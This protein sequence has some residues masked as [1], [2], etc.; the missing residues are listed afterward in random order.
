MK[1]RLLR[2][3]VLFVSISFAGQYAHADRITSVS[4]EPGQVAKL[5]EFKVDDLRNMLK[6]SERVTYCGSTAVWH[7]FIFS[8]SSPTGELSRW[9]GSFKCSRK[10]VAIEKEMEIDASGVAE[11]PNFLL[12]TRRLISCSTDGSLILDGHLLKSELGPIAPG[13][14]LIKRPNQAPEPTPTSVTPPARQ[15]ARQP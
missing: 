1:Y 7:F 4:I 6:G 3:L 9:W 5:Q 2:F 12:G 8:G 15:E 13:S 14:E 10:V 11:I